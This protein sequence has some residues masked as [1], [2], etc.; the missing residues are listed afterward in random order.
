VKRLLLVA[1]IVAIC[2]ALLAGR[3]DIRRLREVY[4]I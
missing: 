3:D 4:G 1:V 2:I